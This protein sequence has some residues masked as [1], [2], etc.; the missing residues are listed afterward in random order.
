L[1]ANTEIAQVARPRIDILLNA[2]EMR[3]GTA[4]RY[5]NHRSGTWRFGEIAQN[6]VTVAHAVACS[7]AYPM[8]L[9]AFDRLYQFIKDGVGDIKRVIIA[10]GG[11]YDNL[12][13]SCLEPGRDREFSLH[14]YPVDYIVCCS[15]GHGQF[16]GSKIPFGF[17]S[18]TQAAFETVFRKAQD[19]AIQRLHMHKRAGN[20]KG[21]I[22]SYL[23]QQDNS[24]PLQPPDLVPRSEVFG[25]PTDFASMSGE[26][27]KRISLRGEQLTRIFL[28]HYC[29]GLE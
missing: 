17:L 28:S 1:F 14:V 19:G 20:L 5:G 15:A 11:I 27:I 2:C 12:G 21:F 23:G 29:P 16:S 24:L 9:P 10:D 25:Y 6:R 7:A 8:F 13:I 26:N 18:R 4:F 22:L 3:T